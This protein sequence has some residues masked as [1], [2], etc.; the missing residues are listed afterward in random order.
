MGLGFTSLEEEELYSSFAETEESSPL[1]N[2]ADTD[3]ASPCQ[4]ASLQEL[5]MNL[6]SW[7][8]S[9]SFH[10]GSQLAAAA[11]SQQQHANG[12]QQHQCTKYISASTIA[13]VM[14]T[15]NYLLAS[16]RKAEV[17]VQLASLG[18]VPILCKIFSR[19]NWSKTESS[20]L[21]SQIGDTTFV[22]IQYLRLV[23]KEKKIDI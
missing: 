7:Y 22:K 3:F 2:L 18:F 12:H 17:Q 21:E 1:E 6:H 10:P 23:S 11:R 19:L 8:S 16:K 4:F 15:L 20:S 5:Q 13:E 14:F 9:S